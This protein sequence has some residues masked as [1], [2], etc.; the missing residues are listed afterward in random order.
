MRAALI[1]VLIVAALAGVAWTQRLELLLW[2]AP[3]LLDWRQPVAPNEPV[4]WPAG[5]DKAAVPP[6]ERPPNV[7][8]ILADDMGFNDVSFFNGGAADGSI[9]TPNIDRIAREGVVFENGYAANAVC[10][11][12]RASILTG[13]YSTRFGFE[14]TPAFKVGATIAEWTNAGQPEA[15]RAVVDRDQLDALPPMRDLG[16]PPEEETVAERLKA[17]GYQ[18]AHIGKW[19]L[20]GAEGMRPEHQGFDDSLYMA[21][22][23]YLP[24]DSPEVVNARI[25]DTI[26]R[27][28][29]ASMQYAAQFNGSHSFEPDGYLTDWYT[30]E[31]LDF[32]EVNRH[33]P[34]FLYLAHWGI[35]NPLQALKSDYDALAHI[36]DHPLR[37]YAAMIVALDRS[38]GRV[39]DQL[40]ALGLDENTLVVF[41]S[42]NGGAGYLGLD[43]VNAPY[44]GWKLTHFEGGTHVPFFMRW[45]ARIEAGTRFEAPVDHIDLMP[46]VVAAAGGTLPEDRVIDGVDLLP[47]VRGEREGVPHE[48]LF[49]RQ[50]YLQTVQHRGLKLITEGRTGQRWLFDLSADPTEQRNLAAAR[51]GDVEALEALLAQ[52]NAEQAAPRWPGVIQIPVMIDKTTQD[53][54]APGDEIAFFPN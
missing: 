10:A 50:G 32:I 30:D 38:V 5:P 40:E 20:G 51:P 24:P 4:R 31:A 37:V 52:H 53:P 45:P 39:L 36:E 34:F 18:T 15:L 12:S 44:R 27:M 22:M 3:K 33:R 1:V 54:W 41:T 28:V 2:A 17:V 26:D 35:H 7:V 46:T 49:W 25:P 8:V 43:D 47:W 29:W 9:R 14:Y 16:M 13:R 11:P 42:D 6:A 19:H 21:G 23:S 48:T